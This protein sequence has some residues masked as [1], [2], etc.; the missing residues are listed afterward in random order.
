[1]NNQLQFGKDIL[2]GTGG[3]GHYDT[4]LQNLLTNYQSTF[5]AWSVSK[6]NISS[7]L[8]LITPKDAQFTCTKRLISNVEKL[9]LV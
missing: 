2:S 7:L 1:M 6:Q 3:N 8:P 5:T 4:L 9:R